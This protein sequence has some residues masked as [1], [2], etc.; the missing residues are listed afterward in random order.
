[1]AQKPYPVEAWSAREACSRFSALGRQQV[2]RFP[3][4]GSPSVERSGERAEE[5]EP[6]WKTPPRKIS[7][8][9]SKVW[10]PA[11]DGLDSL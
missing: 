7:G 6:P 9:R 1:P 2:V 8:S 4:P 10:A 11:P 5:H 3:S